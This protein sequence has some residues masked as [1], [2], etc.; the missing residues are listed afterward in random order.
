MLDQ[1]ESWVTIAVAVYSVLVSIAAITPTKKDD[2]ALDR[3]KHL[4][5]AAT[6][7]LAV[8]GLI[9]GERTLNALMQR[10]VIVQ[11]DNR[12]EAMAK[13]AE[14]LQ[15]PAA[16]LHAVQ[17]GERKWTVTVEGASVGKPN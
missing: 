15:D 13:A 12:Y 8:L 1:V 11:A 2:D 4:A 3:V 9:R 7:L 10:E 5:T 14:M 17:T 6:K 16:E